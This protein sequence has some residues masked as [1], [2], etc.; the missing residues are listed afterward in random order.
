MQDKRGFVDLETCSI[1]AT[2]L[3]RVPCIVRVAS[4]DASVYIKVVHNKELACSLIRCIRVRNL[5]KTLL[6]NFLWTE[7]QNKV[8]RSSDRSDIVLFFLNLKP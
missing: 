8:F 6:C 2:T 7:A 4:P 5:Y 3:C 1:K